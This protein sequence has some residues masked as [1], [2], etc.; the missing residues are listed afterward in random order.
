MDPESVD[1]KDSQ[2]PI[3]QDEA[4][5]DE[6]EIIQ[7]DNNEVCDLYLIEEYDPSPLIPNDQ[8]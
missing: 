7:E 3:T 1:D 8:L 2:T 5:I 4:A 6:D